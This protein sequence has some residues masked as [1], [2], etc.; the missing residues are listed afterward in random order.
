MNTRRI[1]YRGRVQGVGFRF[2]TKNV[3]NNYRVCGYVKNLDDGTVELIAQG[4]G[5]EIRRFLAGVDTEMGRLITGSRS[6]D[7]DAPPVFD[8]FDIAY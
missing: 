5:A 2:R 8:T 4:T 6:S 7:V 3:A 1:I